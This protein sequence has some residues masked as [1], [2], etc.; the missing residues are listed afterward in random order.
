MVT[1]LVFVPIALVIGIF[2][3]ADALSKP[4][5]LRAV[6]VLSGLCL[7]IGVALAV[8]IGELKWLIWS[9]A[10]AASLAWQRVVFHAFSWA[11]GVP[12]ELTSASTPRLFWQDAAYTLTLFLGTGAVI[13]AC[14]ALTDAAAP[15]MVSDPPLPST[16]QI[17]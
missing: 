11:K 6:T 16:G 4:A 17:R 3:G 9:S 14:L 7:A 10:P 8:T 1:A 15:P 13:A 2:A 5:V 12:A